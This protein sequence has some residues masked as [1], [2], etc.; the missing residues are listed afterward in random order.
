M[1]GPI[2]ALFRGMEFR[3]G[4]DRQQALDAENRDER[5]YA[6]GRNDRLDALTEEYRRGSLALQQAAATRAEAAQRALQERIAYGDR[7]KA[8]TRETAP[9]GPLLGKY[10]EAKA[11]PFTGKAFSLDEAL[12]RDPAA[13]DRPAFPGEQPAPGAE[14][15]R[16]PTL[17]EERASSIDQAY[18]QFGGAAQARQAAVDAIKARLA[19]LRT[20]HT[21]SLTLADRIAL[22]RAQAALK[23]RAEG[24]KVDVP[25][26]GIYP[27][28]VGPDGKA[29][30]VGPDELARRRG[31]A[32]QASLA[33][34][35]G[36]ALP[37]D[38]GRR[39]APEANMTPAGPAAPAAPGSEAF[40]GLLMRNVLTGETG[41]VDPNEVGD[42]LASGEYELVQAAGM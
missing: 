11:S 14:G 4:R 21:G 8:L 40:R 27:F 12:A 41:Y 30:Q 22:A 36:L 20:T 15:P 23:A 24:A 31:A 32:S 26:S 38:A 7:S 42:A 5:Q 6:R 33:D 25:S 13:A 28:A 2:D 19:Q 9:L 29:T 1:A 10:P 18:A 37:G 17:G 39:G 3:R 35:L 34:I 16:I